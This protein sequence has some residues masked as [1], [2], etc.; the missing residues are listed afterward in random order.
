MQVSGTIPHLLGCP[1][2]YQVVL[3]E[4]VRVSLDEVKKRVC[5]FGG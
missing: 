5:I 4:V 1:K 2:G 3:A